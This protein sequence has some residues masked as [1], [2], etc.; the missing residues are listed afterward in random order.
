MNNVIKTPEQIQTMRE[1]GKI[2]ANIMK[3]IE[4]AIKPE[5]DI[6]DLEEMFINSCKEFNVEPTCKGYAPYNLPPFPTGLCTSINSQCVHCY[7]I[8]GVILH[9]GDIITVDTVINYKGLNLDM[10]FAKGVGQISEKDKKLI[11]TSKE[12]LRAATERVK[13]GARIGVLSHNMYKTAKKAGFGVL[14]DFAGHGIGKDMHEY[15]EIPCYG[16]KFEGPKLK[17]GMTIC[18][19][20]LICE[21][22]FDVHYNGPWMTEMADKKNFAQFE[23]TIL[24]KKDGFEILTKPEDK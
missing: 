4:D 22:D 13:D 23:N 19:E 14:V 6:W 11:E 9:E 10:S 5:L 2:M 1:G 12:A 18:I 8:K 7:P 17:E 21:G 24:V 3:R 15:P 20:A 16:S